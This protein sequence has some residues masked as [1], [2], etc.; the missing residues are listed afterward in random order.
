MGWKDDDVSGEGG[1]GAFGRVETGQEWMILTAWLARA[2]DR[3]V[4]FRPRMVADGH[5]LIVADPE[6]AQRSFALICSPSHDRSP[7]CSLHFTS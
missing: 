5:R 1:K 7:E 2:S 3:H 6:S 4:T